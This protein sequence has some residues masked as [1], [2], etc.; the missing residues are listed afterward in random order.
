MLTLRKVSNVKDEVKSPR[1]TEFLSE[2]RFE[3]SL[4]L[5]LVAEKWRPFSYRLRRKREKKI[6]MDSTDYW[7]ND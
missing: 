5:F 7:E 2:L 3:F 4:M 6:P 1:K